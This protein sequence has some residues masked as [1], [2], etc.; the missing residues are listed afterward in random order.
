MSRRPSTIKKDCRA[1]PPTPFLGFVFHH[2]LAMWTQLP[3]YRSHPEKETATVKGQ[4]TGVHNCTH[5]IS[6]EV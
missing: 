1:L 4:V 5:F 2:C 6:K 3:T